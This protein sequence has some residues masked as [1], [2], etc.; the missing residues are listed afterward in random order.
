MSDFNSLPN[1]ISHKKLFQLFSKAKKD[2][3]LKISP[4]EKTIKDTIYE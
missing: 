2:L 3:G 4:L 1:S